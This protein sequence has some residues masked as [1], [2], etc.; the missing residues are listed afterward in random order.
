MTTVGRSASSSLEVA[1]PQR[2]YHAVSSAPARSRASKKSSNVTSPSSTV[3]ASQ[4]EAMGSPNL[5]DQTPNMST[6]GT[7]TLHGMAI[8]SIPLDPIEQLVG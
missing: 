5:F 8:A 4:A 2:V 6:V 1:L 7:S 3:A